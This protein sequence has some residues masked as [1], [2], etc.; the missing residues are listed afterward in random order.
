MF[1]LRSERCIQRVVST[2]MRARRHFVD[3]QF[4]AAGK[5]ELD[6]QYAAV[7]HRF[8]EPDGHGFG[9]FRCLFI[10][11]RRNTGG[12]QYAVNVHVFTQR[13]DSDIAINTTCQYDRD[14][15]RQVDAFFQHAGCF[16]QLLKTPEG[17]F[18]VVYREL[19][20]AV[21]TELCGFK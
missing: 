6:R 3:Q 17:V 21:I 7:L 1:E 5:E 2:V 11:V 10:N 19:A 16:L 4:T 12:I 13:V 18:R 14:F 20:L 8:G 9:L 15:L